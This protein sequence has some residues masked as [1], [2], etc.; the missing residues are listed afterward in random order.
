MAGL[1]YL[2]L[3]WSSSQPAVL[4]SAYADLKACQLAGRQAV[5]NMEPKSVAPTVFRFTCVPS[6]QQADRH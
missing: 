4:P 6:G 3:I 5:E 2:V 1:Y